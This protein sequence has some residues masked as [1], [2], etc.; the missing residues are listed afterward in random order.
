MLFDAEDPP[1]E[2]REPRLPAAPMR[3]RYL[4]PELELVERLGFLGAAVARGGH[5][6]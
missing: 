4:T 2:L 1:L 6:P 3:W 5:H